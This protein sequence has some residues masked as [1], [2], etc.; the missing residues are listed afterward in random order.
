M[1]H[2]TESSPGRYGDPL[3]ELMLRVGNGR[4]GDR[5][6]QEGGGHGNSEVEIGRA[7]AIAVLPADQPRGEPQSF[8]WIHQPILIINLRQNQSLPSAGVWIKN[9]LL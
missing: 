7:D 8:A 4:T 6:E 2:I 1:V 3:L 5:F 9:S